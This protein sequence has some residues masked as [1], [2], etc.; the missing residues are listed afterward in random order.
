MEERER[1]RSERRNERVGASRKRKS[2]HTVATA[3]DAVDES[4]ATDIEAFHGT[5]QKRM[6]KR[7]K[8]KEMKKEAAA[9]DLNHHSRMNSEVI[10]IHDDER[11]SDDIPTTVPQKVTS[12]RNQS[13][14]VIMFFV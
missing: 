10:V 11:K 13:T 9:V 8:K 12:N 6:K 14:H 7:E 5:R 4:K 2:E 3:K 1:L